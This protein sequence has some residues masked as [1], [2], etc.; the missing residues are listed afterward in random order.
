MCFSAFSQVHSSREAVRH[1]RR[2]IGPVLTTGVALVTAGVIVANPI[3][4]S[5]ADVQIPAVKLSAGNDETGGMLDP[6][7]LNAI[8]LAPSESDNPF[9]VLK[10]LI[11]SF[12]S[13]ATSVGRNA[14]LDAFVAGVAAVSQPDL[15]AAAVP[16]F[17]PRVVEHPVLTE[18]LVPGFAPSTL[19][20]D[21]PVG[22]PEATSYIPDS[23]SPALGDLVSGL[24]ANVGYVSNGLVEAA[25]AV[26]VMVAAEP[27]LIA[28]TLSALVNGDFDGAF[29][30]AI[31]ALV[32]PIGPPVMLLETF[33]NVFAKR[34]IHT[35]APSPI[36]Q[37]V[38]VRPMTDIAL[39]NVDAADAPAPSIWERARPR[40]VTASV[41]QP[42][43]AALPIRS[44]VLGAATARPEA[45]A[46]VPRRV[47]AAARDVIKAIGEQAGTAVTDATVSVGKA[48]GR[49]GAARTAAAGHRG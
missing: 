40:G 4:A 32:A 23:V 17:A 8:A 29:Q 31:K 5:R 37:L 35:T 46:V 48:V 10:Q 41:S 1:M 47:V 44:A 33:R 24:V 28:D 27:G 20:P 49:P 12:A 7:F 11:T 2:I 36:A 13:D 15:T 21:A 6:A 22:L 26:G 25:F 45:P 43:A 39:A 16:Y 30:T 18:T 14:I 19:G 9:A 3:I 42:A 34:V 38:P